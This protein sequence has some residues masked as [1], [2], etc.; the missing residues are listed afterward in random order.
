MTCSQLFVAM[1][2]GPRLPVCFLRFRIA[3]ATAIQYWQQQLS[4]A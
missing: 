1:L 3:I 4:A 2:V